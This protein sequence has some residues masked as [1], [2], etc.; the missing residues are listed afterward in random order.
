MCD[1]D[2]DGFCLCAHRVIQ[3]APSQSFQQEAEKVR[4]PVSL[5]E[6]CLIGQT[7]QQIFPLPHVLLS[8]IF[9]DVLR[10]G[11]WSIEEKISSLSV[12]RILHTVQIGSHKP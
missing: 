10:G 2:S 12:R 9:R 1:C 8:N 3:V 6:A 7:D 4:Q 11:K 5:C